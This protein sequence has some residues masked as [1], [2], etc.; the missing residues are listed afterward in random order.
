MEI[1]YR[2]TTNNKL[3]K[4]FENEELLNMRD[5]Q[6]YIPLY[7]KFFTLNERNYNS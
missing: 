2:K 1:T 6:N 3:F 5:C 4:D 7:N